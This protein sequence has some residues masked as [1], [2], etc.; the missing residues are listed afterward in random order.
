MPLQVFIEHGYRHCVEQGFEANLPVAAG[1]GPGVS[2]MAL[3]PRAEPWVFRSRTLGGA[4][5][6]ARRTIAVYDDGLAG[7]G[8]DLKLESRALP[9]H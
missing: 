8:S 4:L 5:L 9:L 2:R 7:M 3:C 1:A 6:M